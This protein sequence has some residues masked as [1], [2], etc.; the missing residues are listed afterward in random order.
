LTQNYLKTGT[1]SRGGSQVRQNT[2]QNYQVPNA[3]ASLIKT[4]QQTQSVVQSQVILREN[5]NLMT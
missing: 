3:R 2:N 4:Q 5:G 1:S